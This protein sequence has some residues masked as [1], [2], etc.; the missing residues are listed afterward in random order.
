VVECNLGPSLAV[1]AS[2]TTP[3]AVAEHDVKRRV[4]RDLL[5][6]AGVLPQGAE[7]NGFQRIA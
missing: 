2:P 7:P 6:V 1:E 3:S 5:R 4:V